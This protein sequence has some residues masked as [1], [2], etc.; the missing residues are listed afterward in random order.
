MTK[1]FIAGQFVNVLLI[2]LL[3]CVIKRCSG[4][5]GCDGE[6]LPT[7]APVLPRV[8]LYRR[9]LCVSGSDVSLAL[10]PQPFQT[11][12]VASVMLT[13]TGASML[14]LGLYRC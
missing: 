11:L 2:V 10:Q 3:R 8:I 4:S 7:V 12:P 5:S 13:S 14:L 1:P 9:P 6:P